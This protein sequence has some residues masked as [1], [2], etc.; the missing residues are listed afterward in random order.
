MLKKFDGR[1]ELLHERKPGHRS[2]VSGERNSSFG[3]R[4]IPRRA[5]IDD[6]VA[7]VSPGSAVYH[8]V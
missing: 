6:L 2:F 3:W 1:F 7:M 8:T 4:L 5:E